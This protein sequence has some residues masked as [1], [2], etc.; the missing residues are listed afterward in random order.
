MWRL[1]TWVVTLALIG[2]PASGQTLSGK[3]LVDALRQGGYVLVVRHASSPRDTPD[4]QL[5]N[6][7]NPTLERQLDEQG[8]QTAAAMGEALRSLKIPISDVFTSP[9]YRARETAR[10][11]RLA[12]PR[13]QAELGDGGQSMRELAETYSTWLKRK[14]TEFPHR[15]NTILV[16][17]LPNMSAAFPQ[18]TD[19]LADGETLVLGPDSSGGATLVARVKIEQWPHL[20]D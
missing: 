3:P 1:L 4:R 13:A 8:R 12:N 2:A 20:A 18:W 11:A 9:T 5:A 10:L 19:G 14:V 15:T 17:H 6:P 16:T 7:D